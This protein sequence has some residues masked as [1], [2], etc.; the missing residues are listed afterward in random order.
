MLIVY[1]HEKSGK[2]VETEQRLADLLIRR[3]V[4]RRCTPAEH[5]AFA[6]RS[7]Q[8]TALP[9]RKYVRKAV[10]NGP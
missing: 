9:K 6:D 5:S 8:N 1:V 7:P 2:P 4:A 10:A 3:G